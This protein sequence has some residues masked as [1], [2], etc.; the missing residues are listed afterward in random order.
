MHTCLPQH[1]LVIGHGAQGAACLAAQA[2]VLACTQVPA[3]L[4]GKVH[5]AFQLPTIM[6]SDHCPIGLTLKLDYPQQLGGSKSAGPEEEEGA[7]QRTSM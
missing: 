5:D 6:G 1:L 2:D 3:A 4:A 7:D